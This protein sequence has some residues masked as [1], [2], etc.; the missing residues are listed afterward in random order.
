VPCRHIADDRE[1]TRVEGHAA[2]FGVKAQGGLLCCG[3]ANTER[4]CGSLS[5]T[6]S[7]EGVIAQE[8]GR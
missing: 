1:H 2:V 3:L 5:G 8:N 4:K 6:L 7:S